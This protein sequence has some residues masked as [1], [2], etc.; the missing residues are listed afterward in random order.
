[1]PNCQFTD[2][3]QDG[4]ERDLTDNAKGRTGKV[5]VCLCDDHSK[6]IQ[7]REPEALTWLH[8]FLS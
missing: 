2:C 3:A 4:T 1:M 6:A 5:Y 7:N 8:K